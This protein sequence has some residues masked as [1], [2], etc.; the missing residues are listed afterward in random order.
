MD[1]KSLIKELVSYPAETEWLEFK[2][3]YD[4]PETI[5]QYISALS[6]AAAYV[7]RPYGYVIWGVQDKTHEIVGTDF[8]YRNAEGEPLEHML[9][10][11]L[12]PS[13]AFSF[14]EGKVDGKRIV[15]LRV[16]AAKTV[17]TAFDNNRYCRIGSSKENLR[18]FPE[19]EA[20]LF[21]ILR[22]GLPSVVNTPAE[23]QDLTFEKL[24]TYYA[25]KG[26]QLRTETFKTTLGLCLPDNRF[27]LLAQLLSD[28]NRI[29]LRVSVFDGP[30]KTSPL[31]S[32]RE[33]GNTCILLSLEKVLEYGEVLNVMRADERNRKVARKDVPLFSEAAFREAV[34]NAFVHNRWVSM[35]APAVSVFSNRIEILSRGALAPDQTIDG[36]F[37]GDSVPVNRS[38]SEI[39][40]QLH[41]SE[42]SGRGVPTI[43]EECGRDAVTIY[44]NALIVTIPFTDID[45]KAQVRSWGENQDEVGG[46]LK[47]GLGDSSATKTSINIDKTSINIDSASREERILAL[48]TEKGEVSNSDVASLIGLGPVRTREILRKMVEDDLLLKVGERKTTRYRPK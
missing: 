26:I 25:G 8:T 45:G 42:R 41:I 10:R 16:P 11:K 17:P 37:R 35:E 46:I 23:H 48:A 27:N 34:I 29:P 43:I 21:A 39:F 30:T 12:N 13:C 28:S 20:Q 4:K 18:K 14:C 40:L 9:A 2:A 44:E 1:V 31:Y 36:F 47:I 19:R 3:N 15:M 6:N 24:F 5:G 32:V 7:G 22:D 38:L 33:L